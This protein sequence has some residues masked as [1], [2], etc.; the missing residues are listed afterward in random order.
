MDDFFAVLIQQHTNPRSVQE[1]ACMFVLLFNGCIAQRDQFVESLDKG[2]NRN[3]AAEDGNHGCRCH[4][5]DDTYTVTFWRFGRTD[6]TILRVVLLAR[7][8]QFTR[9]FNGG[10]DTTKMGNACRVVHAIEDL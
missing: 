2:I 10:G 1:D 4:V 6:V 5:L 7:C 3:R 8:N 9:L